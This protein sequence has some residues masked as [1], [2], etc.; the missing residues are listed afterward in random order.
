MRNGASFGLAPL[1][2]HASAQVITQDV[3]VYELPIIVALA[4][5][6]RHPPRGV[7]R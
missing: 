2:A 3:N 4:P 6:K 7:S 5:H 1:D